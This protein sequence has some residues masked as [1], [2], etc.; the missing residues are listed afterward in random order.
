MKLPFFTKEDIKGKRVIVRADL[1]VGE[2]IDKKERRLNILVDLL[3]EISNDAKDITI[4]G[5]RG[6]P[7]GVDENYSLR[8]ISKVVEEL[9]KERI[10]KEKIKTLDM[11][12]MEN[13][14]FGKSEE[15]NSDSYAKHLAE[16]YDVFIN[17][18]FAASHR[19]HSSI[20]GLPKYLTAFAGTHFVKE[21]ENLS[22]VLKNPKKPV[23]F[24]ISG[25]KG[26]KL[27]G[28]EKLKKIADK[29]LI[30]GR[31]P[32]QIH[33]SSPLRKDSKF[34]VA[35]LI[36]DKED[37]TINSIEIFKKEIKQAGTIVLSGP[38]GKFEDESHMH[39]TKEIFSAV[40]DSGAYKVSG[41]GETEVALEKLGFLEKFD[42]T[43][44]GGGAMLKFLS[45]GT[46]PGIEAL[47]H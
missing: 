10:G 3:E 13:L 29:I 41:G 27:I 12:M 26:G 1:D 42:W 21:V 34:V 31:L 23:I 14:R 40:A 28:I 16:D 30:G 45:E 4:I 36:A 17:E 2:K 25:V 24:V 18:A 7:E 19:K 38:L 33:D 8:E 6:R 5:H 15:K 44:V 11:N 22:K 39:G 20:V 43:S 37:I 47:L 9:L 46:L 32:D 35:N